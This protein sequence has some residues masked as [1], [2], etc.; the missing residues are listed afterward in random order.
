MKTNKISKPAKSGAED[1]D[2]EAEM[3]NTDSL[4]EY[5]TEKRSP[6]ALEEEG[7]SKEILDLKQ[8][9]IKSPW[10]L[11]ETF[12]YSFFRSLRLVD[13]NVCDIDEWILTLCNLEELTLS[14]NKISKIQFQNLP[15]KLKVLELGSNDLS[16]LGSSCSSA[17]PELQH[18]GL[19]QNKISSNT[20]C[21]YFTAEYWPNLVSLDLSFNNLDDVCGIVSKIVTLR[22]LRLLMLQGNPLCLT[23]GY[24]GFIVDSLPKLSVLDEKW[25]TP[26][27][28]H[29]FRGLAETKD[30]FVS[31]AQ[32]LVNFGKLKGVPEPVSP[33]QPDL[34]EFPHITYNYYV[35]YEF[36][37]HT[38]DNTLLESAESQKCSDI[39]SPLLQVD[40]ESSYGQDTEESS[41]PEMGPEPVQHTSLPADGPCQQVAKYHTTGKSWANVI[42]CNYKKEHLVTDLCSLKNFLLRGPMV[43][44]KEEKI[45]SWPADKT[46]QSELVKPSSEKKGGEKEK[47]SNK[48]GRG[49]AKKK[50]KDASV[51]LRHDPPIVRELGSLFIKLENLISG[52]YV[53]KTVCDFGIIS[54][55]QTEKAPL[56]LDKKDQIKVHN[57]KDDKKAIKTGRDSVSSQST[58]A[59]SSKGKA[60]GKGMNENEGSEVEQP[61]QPVHLSVEFEVRLCHWESTAE[62]VAATQ[63]QE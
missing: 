37:Q 13:K 8:L 23:P 56:P 5:L 42:E 36:I 48:G 24:R 25:I 2:V 61:A 29:H 26:D 51:E 10:L 50:K 49:S 53:F 46:E 20:E 41:P 60:K 22:K 62:A 47:G 55:E 19:G 59:S 17:P 21:K 54:T 44:V 14:A 12:L 18:L 40:N 16:S 4:I 27:E 43:T 38:I 52:D 58:P 35:T 34:P 6:W 3:E 1:D 28:K 39:K 15:R 7:W 9:L 11:K 31:A 32:V 57:K 45:L 63:K 33:L 30:L